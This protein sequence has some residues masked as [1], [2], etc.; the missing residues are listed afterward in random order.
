L[1]DRTIAIRTLA[2]LYPAPASPSPYAFEIGLV[3]NHHGTPPYLPKINLLATSPKDC[4]LYSPARAVP[5]AFAEDA[6]V[7]PQAVERCA[8]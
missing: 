3:Q 7:D 5:L 4:H 8:W 2:L 1:V 6:F